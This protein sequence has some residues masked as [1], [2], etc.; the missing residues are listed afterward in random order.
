MFDQ[1]KGP[2]IIGTC[3][4]CKEAICAGEDY[5]DIGND[6]LHEDCLIDWARKFHVT[7]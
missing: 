7:A 4:H 5:Y 1:E 6:M 3:V 2:K